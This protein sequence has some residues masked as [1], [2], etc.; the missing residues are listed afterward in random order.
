[1]QSKRISNSHKQIQFNNVK[2]ANYKGI[3]GNWIGNEGVLAIFNALR[4]RQYL[5]YLCKYSN[6]GLVTIK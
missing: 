4:S 5:T 1:M 2:Q 6:K 3:E